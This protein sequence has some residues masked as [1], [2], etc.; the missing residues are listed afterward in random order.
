MNAGRYG[1]EI[2]PYLDT[3]H[4]VGVLKNSSFEVCGHKPSEITKEFNFLIKT[5]TSGLQNIGTVLFK[6]AGLL[7]YVW[8]FYYH[9]ALKEQSCKLKKN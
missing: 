7:K 6:Y 2:T 4:A 3:F 8:P 5:Q 9:Q 1:P